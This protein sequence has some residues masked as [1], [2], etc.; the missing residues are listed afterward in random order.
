MGTEIDEVKPKASFVKFQQF[1]QPT[2]ADGDYTITVTQSV[3]INR[4]EPNGNVVRKAIGPF[5]SAKHFTV[6]GERFELNP[7]DIESVFPPDGNLGDHSKVFP[8]IVLSRSTL[9]WERTVNG[10]QAAAGVPWLALLLFDED[11]KPTPKTKTARELLDTK[12]EEARFP[13]T[14]LESAQQE[15][16]MLTVIDV[17]CSVL[18]AIM[19]TG[20][21]LKLLTHVRFGTC[22]NDK[23][24]GEELAI[25]IA[26]RLPQK[27]KSSTAHL[28]SIEGRFTNVGGTPSKYGFDFEGIKD[29]ELIRLV[30]LK[31]WSFACESHDKDFKQLLI[32]LNNTPS[33]LR[34][35]DVPQEDAQKLFSKGYVVMPHH[36]RGGDRTVSWF[37]G[38]LI[39]G[40]NLSP[41]FALPVRT[42]D[43]LV[44]YD[45]E[46]SMFDVSY[47]AAWELG[48]LLT[49]QD[50]DFSTS[51]Y[52]WKREYAQHMAQKAQRV[53]HLPFQK[54]TR[55]YVPEELTAWFK[56]LRKL[57]GVPFNYL[58]PDERMLPAESIRFFRVDLAWLDCLADGAF[59]IGRVASS[60]YEADRL[61]GQASPAVVGIAPML[62][63][64]LLRSEVVSG[65]PG[66]LVD[67]YSDQNGEHRLRE[68]RIDR[69]ASGVLLSIFEGEAARVEIHQKPETLHFGLHADTGA[70]S[71][72]LRNSEGRELKAKVVLNSK[73][74]HSD[75]QRILNISAFAESVRHELSETL[76]QTLPP[77]SSAEFGLEMVEGVEKIIFLAGN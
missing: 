13:K 51:L 60:D 12:A 44:R 7:I 11:Q 23:L 17:P 15:S 45:P 55:V 3:T 49:L 4:T 10:E 37:H 76:S 69:L 66:L 57:E 58:V 68:V 19:P 61:H 43:E 8:H 25:V 16:D 21:E 29:H 20:E 47:A 26:N 42:A 50:K 6:A 40:K 24:V 48:R 46:L 32:G 1:H 28:V 59:S 77:L 5:E 34:L 67:A 64:F 31:S 33:T 9:P 53:R 72:N 71:K 70:L 63:G 35:P 18:K 73:H 30:S 65:W 36:F 75:P 56:S 38:P 52:Q 2:L 27:G 22:A 41:K 39:P 74:W 62:T 54:D 14:E